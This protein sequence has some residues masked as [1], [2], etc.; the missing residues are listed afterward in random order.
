[1]IYRKFNTNEAST[2]L[3]AAG[4]RTTPGSSYP[5]LGGP[6][7]RLA[8]LFRPSFH[9]SGVPTTKPWQHTQLVSPQVRLVAVPSIFNLGDTR[10]QCPN[11]SFNGVDPF[12]PR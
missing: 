8:H 7:S 6:M 4:L 5:S 9:P 1:M 11:T 10:Q 3:L 12:V 2:L